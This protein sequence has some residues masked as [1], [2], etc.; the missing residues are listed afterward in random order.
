MDKLIKNDLYD[1]MDLLNKLYALSFLKD[2]D[3]F[4]EVQKIMMST[5]E[6]DRETKL[7]TSEYS[8]SPAPENNLYSM[9][10]LYRLI[11]D[12][13]KKRKKAQ[14]AVFAAEMDIKIDEKKHTLDAMRG[15]ILLELIKRNMTSAQNSSSAKKGKSKKADPSKKDFMDMWI[16]F[17]KKNRE[18]K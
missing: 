2:K 4:N 6:N 3:R 15:I 9:E 1:M 10:G 7:S 13:S 14:L 8:S 11:E 18:R 12:M 17:Y 16:D 5:L